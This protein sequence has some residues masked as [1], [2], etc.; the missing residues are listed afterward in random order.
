MLFRSPFT[1]FQLYGGAVYQSVKGDVALRGNSYSEAFNGYDAK[2]KQNHA[3]GWLAG[4]SYQIPD[5]AL[6]AAVTYRSKIDHDMQVTETMFGEPLDV[7]TP[8][9]TTITTPQSVNIDF[10]TGVYKDTLAYANLRWVNWKDFHIRPTQFG[11]V[12]EYLTDLISKGSYTGGFDL[13]SY[14]KDQWAATLGIGH[15]FTEKWSASTEVS[16]DS[17]TGNPASTLNPTKG[18]WGLGLGVQFNPAEN[19]F[20]AGGIKYFWLGD[21]VAEDGTYYIPVAGIKP[22]AEQ[23]DFKDN[24]AIAYGLKIGYKF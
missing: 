5:I 19:Y 18:S 10:Q 3:V 2:F 13:D 21:V 11:A 7:T 12:T 20:I 17:G 15:Q 6:K 24:S 16:W 23:A 4:L 8:S 1:N 22:I 14:Q 9:K